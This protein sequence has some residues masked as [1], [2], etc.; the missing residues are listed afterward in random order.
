MMQKSLVEETRMSISST[1]V[2]M[3]TSWMPPIDVCR[4]QMVSSGQWIH[5]LQN[6]GESPILNTVNNHPV[7]KRT[8][9]SCSQKS[10]LRHALPL[11]GI[12]DQTRRFSG[13]SPC[14]AEAL[15]TRQEKN[16]R[17]AGTAAKSDRAPGPAN[18]SDSQKQQG[19]VDQPGP[20]RHPSHRSWNVMPA[21][22]REQLY[23]SVFESAG[24][25]VGALSLLFFQ[26]RRP[27]VVTFESQLATRPHR[28]L[29]STAFESQLATRPQRWSKTFLSGAPAWRLDLPP[30]EVGD[31]WSPCPNQ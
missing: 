30:N 21:V 22:G 14:S 19:D 1:T 12:P 8:Q 25:W 7:Y 3:S 9:I 23:L 24:S 27:R 10:R 5:E 26:G 11:Q 20:T 31:K 17:K 15:Q 2:S 6:R 4:A 29:K 16:T 28:W 18:Q 13:R